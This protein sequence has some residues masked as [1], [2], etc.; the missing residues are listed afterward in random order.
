MVICGWS[1]ESE[2]QSFFDL[3]TNQEGDRMFYK[4]K[5]RKSIERRKGK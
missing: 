5:E 3:K 1:S 2:L 4:S